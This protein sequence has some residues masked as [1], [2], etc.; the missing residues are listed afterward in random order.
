MPGANLNRCQSPTGTGDSARNA[1]RAE[2]L[3]LAELQS[4]VDAL[5]RRVNESW[6]FGS[7]WKRTR[8]ILFNILIYIGTEGLDR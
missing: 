3:S 8:G 1:H 2:Q 4:R 7:L 5:E 6:F